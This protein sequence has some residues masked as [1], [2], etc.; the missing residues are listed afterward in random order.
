MKTACLSGAAKLAWRQ[1]GEKK[2]ALCANAVKKLGHRAARSQRGTSAV[3]DF[4]Y[5]FPFSY[6]IL[7]STEHGASAVENLGFPRH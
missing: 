1:R 6:T 4:A 2:N 5:F 7:T 3:V